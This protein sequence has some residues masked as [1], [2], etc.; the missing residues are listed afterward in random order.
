MPCQDRELNRI[1]GNSIAIPVVGAVIA[2]LLASIEIAPKKK[3]QLPAAANVPSC[4]VWI[5]LPRVAERAGKFDC[6]YQSKLKK[7][8]MKRPAASVQPHQTLDRFVRRKA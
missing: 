7:Q 6:L 1:A 2:V 8:E 4:P 3:G 5:G